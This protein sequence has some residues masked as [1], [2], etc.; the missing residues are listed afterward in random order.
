MG[1]DDVP[2]VADWFWNFRDIAAFDRNLPVPVNLEAVRES[3]RSAL[4]YADPPRALWYVAEDGAGTA[5]GIGGLQAIN[6]VHGDAVLPLFIAEPARGKGLALAISVVLADLA[7]DTLRLNRLTTFYRD[8][9]DAT[10]R[11]VE[12]MGFAQEGRLRQ[13]WYG[14]GV[15]H[16]LIQVGMLHN[17]WLDGRAALKAELETSSKTPGVLSINLERT[18]PKRQ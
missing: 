11:I 10:K 12:R 3:W 1:F 14:D 5:L 16:D 18:P 17:E 2:T 7:F 8:D 13:A 9:N 4:E 6:Y 15:H